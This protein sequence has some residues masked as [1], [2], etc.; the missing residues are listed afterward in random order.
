MNEIE[1]IQKL[2]SVGD[3][4]LPKI[5]VVGGV[6]AEIAESEQ[7]IQTQRRQRIQLFVGAGSAVAA[8]AAV[9]A[10]SVRMLMSAADPFNSLFTQMV[11]VTQ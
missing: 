4:R 11:M 2:A 5:D 1:Y 8:A 9:I 3:D 7:D 6:L 10:I